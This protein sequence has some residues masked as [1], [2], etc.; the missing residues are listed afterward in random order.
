MAS[1]L[2]VTAFIVYFVKRRNVIK[3][4]QHKKS[5]SKSKNKSKSTNQKQN[6]DMILQKSY[7][8]PCID[9][10]DDKDYFIVSK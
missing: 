1:V 10:E 8:E 2:V 7:S 5:K 6:N 9:C 4:E 3:T